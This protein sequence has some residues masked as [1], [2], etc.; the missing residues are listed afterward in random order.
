AGICRTA[1]NGR[2]LDCNESFARIFGYQSREDV[3]SAGAP[4]LYFR[5]KDRRAFLAKLRKN[6]MLNNIELR[7]RRKDGSPVWVLGNASLVEGEQGEPAV[8]EGIWIDVTER[9]EVEEQLRAL[10]ARL[11]MVREEERTTIAREIHDQLGQAL[12]RLKIELSLLAAEI[13]KGRQTLHRKV[14]SMSTLFDSTIQGVRGFSA[15]LRPPILD[16]F[17]LTATIE[18]EV[19]EFGDRTGVDCEFIGP[20]DLALDLERSTA[21]FRILQEAFTNIARH[22]KA[23]RVVT[24]L[25]K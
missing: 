12:T 23:T 15:R 20:E 6:H 9:R 2:I 18:Q 10:S 11:Q 8:V 5:P 22:A 17:G 14:V 3:L 21:L 1:I 19:L 7:L 13:P 24:R 25:A 16:H 4:S